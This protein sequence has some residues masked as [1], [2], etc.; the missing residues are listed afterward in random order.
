MKAK[1]I[2][3]LLLASAMTLS[4]VACGGSATTETS[5]EAE[6]AVEETEAETETETESE[7][8]APAEEAASASG[9]VSLDFEDGV[10]GFVGNDKSV[11]TSS[12]DSVITVEDYNGS[13]AL[14]VTPQGK[15][16]PMENS[17]HLQVIF[18]HSLAKITQN[19]IRNGLYILRMQIRRLSATQ[20]LMISPL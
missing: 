15:K 3:A 6:T 2:M 9:E 1:K 4:L 14:K 12:D 10:I 11:T 7:E 17:S 16:I 5:S 20:F 18:M 13:K 8:E 19:V